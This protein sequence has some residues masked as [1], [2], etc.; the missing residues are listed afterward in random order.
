MSSITDKATGPIIKSDRTG[1]TRY[2]AQYKRD[3]LAA[4]MSSSLSA[5]DFAKQYGIKYPTFATWIAARKGTE[6][7]LS[8]GQPAFLIAQ[9]A[10]PSDGAV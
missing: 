1:R 7:T 2:T 10:A 9:L 8:S 5:P 6:P 4:F 3:V